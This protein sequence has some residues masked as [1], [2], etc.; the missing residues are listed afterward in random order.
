MPN[1]RKADDELEKALEDSFPASDPPA[2]SQPVKS[3]KGEKSVAIEDKDSDEDYEAEDTAED[4]GIE[5]DGIE[6]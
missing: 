3:G 4:D 6:E 5:E 1:P 2:M